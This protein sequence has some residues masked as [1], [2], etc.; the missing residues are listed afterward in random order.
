[1][2]KE[3]S[4]TRSTDSFPHWETIL[5][6]VLCLL[7]GA[8]IGGLSVFYWQQAVKE[9]EKNEAVV[10]VRN[11]VAAQGSHL[12]YQ[13][14]DWVSYTNPSNGFS[15]SYPGGYAIDTSTANVINLTKDN[16]QTLQS[17]IT[18][19]YLATDTYR[20]KKG[21][22]LQAYVTENF[23]LNE[24]GKVKPVSGIAGEQAVRGDDNTGQVVESHNYYF[25][26]D[27]QLYSL[28]FQGTTSSLE[29]ALLDSITFT[30]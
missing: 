9:V 16:G 2:A 6:I 30:K 8:T 24:K 18:I 13:E 3:I 11:E 14:A 21:T 20:P 15:F 28:S 27:G 10:E 29:K 4:R 22:D 1:M 19:S 12:N 26:K 5:I 17:V 25:V 23:W 7:V